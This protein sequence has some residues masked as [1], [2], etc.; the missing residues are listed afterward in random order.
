MKEYISGYYCR[1][2]LHLQIMN[3]DSNRRILE[4]L[5][6]VYPDGL[7]VEQ[8]AKKTKLPIKTIYAQK[9]EL[10]RE[11]YINHLE[12]EEQEGEDNPR[13]GR[14]SAA[15][16]SKEEDRRKRV[17]IVIEDAS[18]YHDPYEGKKPTP[19]PPGNV[20]FSDAFTEAWDNIVEKEQ[21][22]SLC[23]ELLRFISRIFN[24]TDELTSGKEDRKMVKNWIP[25]VLN[26]D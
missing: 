18:G 4:A 10:Y 9:A 3:K 12:L 1:D 14:P 20:I 2:D 16:R 15:S 22:E 11:Y 8:L 13:R 5:R 7:T 17:R 6:K 26:A 21:Q 19:L 25:A 23:N 24:S